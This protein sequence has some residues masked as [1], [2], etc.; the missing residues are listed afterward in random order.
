MM[1]PTTW[2]DQNTEKVELYEELVKTVISENTLLR[3]KIELIALGKRMNV[4]RNIVRI[5]EFDDAT[6][7][8]CHAFSVE[9][10]TLLGHGNLGRD[11]HL[12]GDRDHRAHHKC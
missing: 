8:D 10:F 1:D 4:V 2:L 7:R 11:C 6:S 9:G 5:D 12:R 3:A